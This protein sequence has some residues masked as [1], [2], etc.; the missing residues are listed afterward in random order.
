LGGLPKDLN[1]A[2]EGTVVIRIGD[3]NTTCDNVIV[4]QGHTG[5][6]NDWWVGGPFMKTAYIGN[7][8]GIMQTCHN[9]PVPMIAIFTWANKSNWFTVALSPL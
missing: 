2:V 9:G 3:Q 4:A 1:F 7:Y 8:T 6:Y 5:A